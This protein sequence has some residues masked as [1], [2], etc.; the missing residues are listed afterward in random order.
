ML[1]KKLKEQI[2]YGN[3][4]SDKE[5]DIKALYI[6]MA[7]IVGFALFFALISTNSDKTKHPEQPKQERNISDLVGEQQPTETAHMQ[8][9]TVTNEEQYT[10]AEKQADINAYKNKFIKELKNNYKSML[11]DLQVNKQYYT[12]SDKITRNITVKIKINKNGSIDNNQVDYYITQPLLIKEAILH[13]VYNDNE[14]R[15]YFDPLPK[16]YNKDSLVLNVVFT[17]NDVDFAEKI[18]STNTTTKSKPT[19]NA[20][21]NTKVT[22]QKP[23]INPAKETKEIP[24]N[25]YYNSREYLYN[26]KILLRNNYDPSYSVDCSMVVVPTVSVKILKDNW[27]GDIA[28]NFLSSINSQI[29]KYYD[30]QGNI[31]PVIIKFDEKSIVKVELQYATD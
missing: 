14:E 9:Q 17:S 22:T 1:D 12:D 25:K 29:P 8:Q 24:Q 30:K 26:V 11:N 5:I 23:S 16:S 18:K 31:V 4:Q 15:A 19:T 7:V 6:F 2:Y 28:Y 21:N 3:N 10:E 20:T 27:N 13:T